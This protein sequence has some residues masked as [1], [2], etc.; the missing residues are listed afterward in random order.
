MLKK[1]I[2]SRRTGMTDRSKYFPKVSGWT[3]SKKKKPHPYDLVDIRLADDKTVTCWWNGKEWENRKQVFS[4]VREW[5]RH[6]GR[7]VKL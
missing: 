7:V 2:K 5:K 4:D 3:D 6:D 1:R